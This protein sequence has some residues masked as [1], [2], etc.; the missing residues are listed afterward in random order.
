MNRRRLPEEPLPLTSGGATDVDEQA[1]AKLLERYAVAPPDDL[2]VERVWQRLARP[3]SPAP[4][5]ADRRL[6]RA[7]GLLAPV[8]AL[9]SVAVLGLV[10]LRGPARLS[11][12][13]AQ[14]PAQA[15]AQP[16]AQ[17]AAQIV[18]AARTAELAAAHGGVF[19]SRPA[20]RWQPG[21]EGQVLAESQSL[22]TDASGRAVLD[23]P[24]IAAVLMTPGTD[25][26][27]ERL[28]GGTFLR[29]SRGSVVARV[30]KRP[31]SEP[32]VILTDRFSVKVVGTLFQVDQDR[33]AAGTGA[34]PTGDPLDAN[35]RTAVTV[36]EGTVE[37]TAADGRAWRVGAGRSW[38]SSAP[39][40]LGTAAIADPVRTLLE[41]GLRRVNPAE[42]ERDLQAV[43][44]QSAVGRA[45]ARSG[46]A[47]AASE[48]APAM[49][50][51]TRDPARSR[52]SSGLA[53]PE[54]ARGSVAASPP[55]P[56]VLAERDPIQPV[57]R[58]VL[59]PAVP[60]P[61]SPAAAA[62]TAGAYANGLALERRGKLE[63]AAAELRR[64]DEDDPG[65][66]DLALY[67]L[68]RLFQHRLH[69]SQN[70]L[71]AFE[72]YRSRYPGGALLPEVDLAVL[73]V[74]MAAGN[75]KAALAE[76]GRFLATHPASERADEVRLL[77]GNLLRE[78]GD[79]HAAL[80]A[81]AQVAAP[82]FADE[83]LYETAY[84]QRKLGDGAAARASLQAYRRRFPAGVHRDQVSTELRE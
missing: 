74:E 82:A 69:D 76:S 15:V 5:R 62:P 14:P 19:F 68:G 17:P 81:Y 77:H 26:A 60:P 38:I 79:C 34:G 21:E 46:D 6:A 75:R 32:F 73:E 64:A 31:P 28:N 72:S 44:D 78:G 59:P 50:R 39:E 23:V 43:G 3:I 55:P 65:H 4:K 8:A 41:D 49:L 80:E 84:C 9:A 71:A 35:D 40:Q 53:A 27:I 30:S 48:V 22:R 70:A 24:G 36:R 2:T 56:L 61:P 18:P 63:A 47:A 25:V 16:A 66:A 45:G 20:E 7:L 29:L 33:R 12:P 52:P 1:A 83:A 11:K 10:L 54:S 42:L 51:A 58:A 37:I 13:L 67:A 57:D